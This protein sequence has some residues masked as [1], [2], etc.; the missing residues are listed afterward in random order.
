MKA[1][2]G[3]LLVLALACYGCSDDDKTPIDGGVDTTLVD[4]SMD[5]TLEVAPQETA[6]QD[7]STKEAAADQAT[8]DSSPV[9]AV[10]E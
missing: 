7:V 6:P 9:D 5:A 3:L 1:L 10:S 8:V 4:A 2:I